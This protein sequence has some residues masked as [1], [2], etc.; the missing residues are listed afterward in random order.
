[1]LFFFFFS[2]RRRHTRSKR[3]WS[4]DVCSSDLARVG[5]VGCSD[6]AR[7]VRSRYRE[8]PRRSRPPPASRTERHRIY[9]HDH[10][11]L[12]RRQSAE[13]IGRASCRERVWIG[14]GEGS[15]KKKKEESEY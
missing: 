3:D 9:E 4:S 14:G 12:D 10:L 5:T 7:C 1:V 13:E 2:S 6:A 8:G 11:A 15:L